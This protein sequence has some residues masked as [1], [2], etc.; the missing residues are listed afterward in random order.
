MAAKDNS[1]YAKEFFETYGEEV[2][3]MLKEAKKVKA[4]PA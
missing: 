1:R 3:A 4:I 2:P